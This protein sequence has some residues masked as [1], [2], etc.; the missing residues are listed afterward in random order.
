MPAGPSPVDGFGLNVLAH[1]FY[2]VEYW[3]FAAVHLT[4]R[5]VV[6]GLSIPH[7]AFHYLA[8]R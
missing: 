4:G 5:L 1:N 3:L 6:E 2:F 8:D 7:S